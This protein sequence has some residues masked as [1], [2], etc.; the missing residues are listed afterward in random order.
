LNH[1]K[2]DTIL[3][4]EKKNESDEGL[5]RKVKLLKKIG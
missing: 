1:L 3:H 5:D 4:F 2:F